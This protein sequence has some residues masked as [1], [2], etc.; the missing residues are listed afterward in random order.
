MQRDAPD[1]VLGKAERCHIVAGGG[2]AEGQGGRP[3]KCPGCSAGARCSRQ[4]APL[5][6]SSGATRG[7]L[8]G[9]SEMQ[10]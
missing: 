1:V 5:P 3:Q 4:P 9:G 10:R 2:L 7:E 8:R 6:P